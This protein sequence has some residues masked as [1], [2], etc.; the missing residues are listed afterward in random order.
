M[1][2]LLCISILNL[3]QRFGNLCQVL[4]GKGFVSLYI[5]SPPAEVGRIAQGLPGPGTTR[6]TGNIA[7][8]QHAFCSQ[9]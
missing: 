1:Q 5:I 2:L 8:S 6:N 3:C 4:M 9:W 7:F